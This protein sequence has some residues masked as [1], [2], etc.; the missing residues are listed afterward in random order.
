MSGGVLAQT[1]RFYICL[2]LTA[3]EDHEGQAARGDVPNEG[4]HDSSMIMLG[5][6]G[7]GGGPARRPRPRAW[8]GSQGTTGHL[9]EEKSSPQQLPYIL[10]LGG[11]LW[12]HHWVLRVIPGQLLGM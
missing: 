5:Q 8:S 11:E 6:G 4:V 2:H 1:I 10:D 12:A 7:V 9:P 3:A